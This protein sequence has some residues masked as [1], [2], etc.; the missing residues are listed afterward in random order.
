MKICVYCA[1]SAK[2]D[3]MYFDATEKLALEFVKAKIDVI[4]GGGAIGLMGKLADTIIENGGK[5]K[6]IM[7]KFM[8]E[9]EWAH[10]KVVDFEFTDSMHERK[11]KFLEDIDGLVTLPGGSGTLEELL[12]A[13]TLKRLG[14][15]TKPIIIL[16]TNGFYDPLRTML[17]KCVSEQFMH[18]KHLEMWSFVD[19]PEEVIDSIINAPTWEQ[20]AINFATNK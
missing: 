9:V 1:S 7:P 12:E 15:F 18:E 2:V 4:Y 3:R 10:K 6:G 19:N 5:I 16:N 8:N 11:A 17:E 13:I 20:S 14:Q